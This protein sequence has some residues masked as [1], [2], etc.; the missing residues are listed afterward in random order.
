MVEAQAKRAMTV[1]EIILISW[2]RRM[3]ELGDKAEYIDEKG[4]CWGNKQ[5]ERIQKHKPGHKCN[6]IHAGERRSTLKRVR[7]GLKNTAER[8]TCA[9]ADWSNCVNHLRA[10][11]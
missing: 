1:Y 4:T 7:V 9:L 11:R 8:C 10:S 6:S 5:L 2:P 3:K